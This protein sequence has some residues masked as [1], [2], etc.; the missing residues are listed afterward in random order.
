MSQAQGI[1]KNK[2]LEGGDMR[3]RLNAVNIV[4]YFAF[5]FL[6]LIFLSQSARAQ[7]ENEGHEKL[8]W[9]FDFR[10]YEHK[11]KVDDN[12]L[13]K[14][15]A[16]EDYLMGSPAVAKDG[17][18]YFVT[19]NGFLYALSADGKLKWEAGG[20][21]SEIGDI[22]GV[23]I[24]GDDGT[25]YTST[26]AFNS[27]GTVKW[28]ME[29]SLD[30]M[31]LGSD[32]MLYG[33]SGYNDFYAVNADDG[34]VK[35]KFTC[36][37]TAKKLTDEYG[38]EIATIECFSYLKSY[39][40]IGRDGTIYV[41]SQEG[42]LYALTTDGE[43]KWKYKTQGAIF[44]SPVI[45]NNGTIY[46]GDSSPDSS[47]GYVYAITPEGKAKWKY[48]DT[49]LTAWNEAPAIG[50]DETLYFGIG[51]CGDAECPHPTVFAIKEGALKWKASAY[52]DTAMTPA[53]GTDGTV[54]V[55]SGNSY[56]WVFNNGKKIWRVKTNAIIGVSPAL[57]SDGTLYVGSDKFYAIKTN[58][59]PAKSSW[60]KFRGNLRNTG[61]VMD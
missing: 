42:F 5:L 59:T 57:L 27:D 32:G 54:Y 45:G 44:S 7:K 39:P 29:E 12:Y 10:M 51:R 2:S 50:A 34:K 17:T 33:T 3:K 30:A 16:K 1:M 55:G 22:S 61:N 56:L 6:S 38:D 36:K 9:V 43:V 49:E 46:I 19:V 47:V 20:K 53:I 60:Y 52:W 31:A 8:K 28:A 4:F 41:P 15:Q 35:W 23:P 24:A 11:N 14:E 25:I 13:T 26:K 48:K 40:A 18:I 21:G 37:D 58:N